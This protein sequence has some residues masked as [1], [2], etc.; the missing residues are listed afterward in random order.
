MILKKDLFK[1]MKNAV[2]GKTVENARN[3]INSE[4]VKTPERFERVLNEPYFKYSHIINENLVGVE[5][6]RPITKLNKSIYVGM[7]ILEL[8]KLHMYR[9]YYD[10]LKE[11]YGDNV[12]LAYTDTDSYISKIETEDVY[13]D[14][15]KLGN[16]FD[17]SNY[18]KS[19]NNY[20]NINNKKLGFFK[21]EME[22]KIMTEYVGLKPKMYCIEKEKEA[23]GY[24]KEKKKTEKQQ[25]EA[26]GHEDD[27]DE[28]DC[29]NKAKGIPK[30]KVKQLTLE[31]YKKT[32]YENEKDHVNFNSLRTCKH[33]I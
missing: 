16:Y 31:D 22:G 7:S 4:L 19:H 27:N 2:F 25:K 21:D 5:K 17:F 13:D 3:H 9:F 15:K 28:D 33:T 23:E 11:R 29:H 8:S 14:F 6:T 32:L 12:R 24:E 30:C 18:D 10:V 20:S 26:E 1:L